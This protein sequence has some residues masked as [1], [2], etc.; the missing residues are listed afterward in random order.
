[1][2]AKL[3]RASFSKELHI[4]LAAKC[5]QPVGHDLMHA[6]SSPSL[7]R[8]VQQRAFEDAVGFGFISECRT[9]SL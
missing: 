6:G 8:S 1:M 9:G 2:I 4:V 7:T 3:F 5:R